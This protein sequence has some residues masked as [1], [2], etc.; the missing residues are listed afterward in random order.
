MRPTRVAV[1][2]GHRP[3]K[4]TFEIIIINLISYLIF[5]GIA[6]IIMWPQISNHA[7][8]AGTDS[9][10]HMNRFYETAMQIKTGHFSY[11]QSIFAFHQTGRLVNAFYGPLMAYVFGG[12]LLLCKNWINFQIVNSLLVLSLSGWLMYVLAVKSN[13]KRW[14]ALVMGTMYMTC[15]SV[16]IWPTAQKFTGLGAAF[17]PLAILCGIKM[18]NNHQ[19]RVL[20]LAMT[21]TLLVQTHLMSSLVAI[22]ALIPMFI[23]GWVTSHHRADMFTNAFKAAGL[24]ILLT[25]NVWGSIVEMFTTNHIIPVFPQQD[26][27]KGTIYFT[28]G[29]LAYLG[30]IMTIVALLVTLTLIFRWKYYDY[31]WKTIVFISWFFLWLSSAWFPWHWAHK[32]WTAFANLIQF[33]RRFMIIAIILLLLAFG[34]ICS[35]RSP[36]A[37]LSYKGF[38]LHNLKLIM[39]LI[40]LVC[41][42]GGLRSTMNQEVKQYQSDEVLNEPSN[43]LHIK[44]K[45]PGQLRHA[46]Q[47]SDLHLAIQA[48]TKS[49]PDYLPSSASLRTN[50][51]YYH[52]H[53]YHRE[54]VQL[55]DDNSVFRHWIINRDQLSLHWMNHKRRS[56]VT[57]LPLVAYHQTQ[58]TING[59]PVSDPRISK[60]GALKVH[61]RPGW[62]RVTIE[63][64]PDFS[65]GLMMAITIMTWLVLAG[66]LMVYRRRP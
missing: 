61:A 8:I 16:S 28:H 48:I 10:F 41:S 35:R 26:L 27:M 34:Q 15:Y 39:L 54:N 3:P 14:A 46:F 23:V 59:R 5:L 64:H 65:L 52:L 24:T 12:L 58:V 37:D 50:H 43:M 66:F 60:V 44:S 4:S 53:P 1:H 57:I 42:V 55:D 49:T 6:A 17:L 33:P 20:P 56:K 63:F 29:H 11:F 32:H 51:D 62:N 31:R 21:M 30:T 22:M 13:V 47:S 19:I 18:L 25:G 40:F 2:E 38:K 7:F 45:T 36:L 9:A